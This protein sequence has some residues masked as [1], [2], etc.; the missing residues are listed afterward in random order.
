LF[1]ASTEKDSIF[2]C[3]G[4]VSPDLNNP[5][6]PFAIPITYET[7]QDISTYWYDSVDRMREALF[8][9]NVKK[10]CGNKATSAHYISLPLFCFEPRCMD[11]GKYFP[12]R[13]TST[14]RAMR[15]SFVCFLVQDS[16]TSMNT[17]MVLPECLIEM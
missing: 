16:L 8:G 15:F 2:S 12:Q 11:P 6:P 5:S 1:H 9:Q 14:L 10:S 3:G 17:C 4:Y 13:I 7:I